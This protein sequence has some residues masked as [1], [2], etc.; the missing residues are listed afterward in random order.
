[1]AV[2]DDAAGGGKNSGTAKVYALLNYNYLFFPVTLLT[3]FIGM[4]SLVWTGGAQDLV[5]FVFP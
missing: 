3:V 5:Q 2:K 1:M 4:D